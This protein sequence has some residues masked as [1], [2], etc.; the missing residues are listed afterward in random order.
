[1]KNPERVAELLAELRALAENDFERH[2]L[3]VLEKDLIAPPKVEQVDETRQKFNDAIYRQTKDGHLF[4]NEP[5]HRAV[6]SYYNGEIPVGYHIHHVDFDK[7]NNQIE[8][9][10]CIPQNEHMK[11]HK[12]L[13]TQVENVCQT[14]GKKFFS[15]AKKNFCSQTCWQKSKGEIKTCAFCNQEFLAYI[16]GQECCCQ[17]CA[18]ALQT[19]RKKQIVR[20]CQNCGKEFTGR[21]GKFCC[22]K[23]YQQFRYR[24]E[25][26][27]RTCI[28]CG[29]TFWASKHSQGKTCSHRCAGKLS[30]SGKAK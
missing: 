9:L 4:Y 13:E 28:V 5:I 26:V 20:V 10:V 6:W 18:Y 25:T 8:N 17:K 16:E 21:I 15:K 22:N 11:L 30:Y 29:K 1:M 27:E 7:S 12:S 14:C 23:C 24:T 19:Q 3:D 2:R